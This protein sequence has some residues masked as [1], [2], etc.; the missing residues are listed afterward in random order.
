MIKI[1]TGR[2]GKYVEW[3]DKKIFSDDHFPEDSVFMA[4]LD[5][6]EIR[7]VTVFTDYRGDSIGMHVAGAFKGWMTPRYVRAVFHYVFNQLGCKRATGLVRPDNLK[8]LITDLKLGFKFE[9][10]LRRADCDGSDLYVLGMTKE[11]CRWI[12]KDTTGGKE[13]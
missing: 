13:E 7:G 9:G 4:L 3:A 11:E 1:L 2:G 8:A 12:K 10:C 5:G 6:E